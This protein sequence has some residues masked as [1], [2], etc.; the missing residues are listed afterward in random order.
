MKKASAVGVGL[1]AMIVAGPA[2]AAPIPALKP[3]PSYE[4]SN[5]AGDPNP[6][7][8]SPIGRNVV[9]ASIASD[10]SNILVNATLKEDE[11]GEKAG[12]VLDLYIDTDGDAATGGKAYWGKDAKPPK[13][14]YEYRAQLSVCLAYDENV[15]AC[16][17]G[18][19]V[20]P[21]SRHARIVL[22][23]FKGTAGADLD[24]MNSDSLINGFGP[25]AIPSPVACSRA[26]SR[27]PSWA[28]SRARPF[29]SRLARATSPARRAFFPISSSPSSNQASGD[30]W[31]RGRG[32]APPRRGLPYAPCLS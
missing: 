26:R 4:Y 30:S 6:K 22:D 25:P 28:S 12:P 29:G 15:G 11:H 27:T 14:G 32:R 31:R 9:K 5:P 17:G 20:P 7:Y 1:C 21:K 16:A 10:G 24:G 13:A 8:G 3:V 23:K 19:P 18:P 2:S